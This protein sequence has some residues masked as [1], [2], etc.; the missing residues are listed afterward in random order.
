MGSNWIINGASID[1]PNS[2]NSYLAIECTGGVLEVDNV[3]ISNS[4]YGIYGTG[5]GGHI[6]NT[7]IDVYASS[8]GVKIENNS[9]MSLYKNTIT[10]N[11][12][13]TGIW[14]ETNATVVTNSNIVDG[15]A[16]RYAGQQP[17]HSPNLSILQ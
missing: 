14:S 16:N 8:Y 9:T 6:K 5:V 15:F 3:T 11:S 13:G 12:A 10:G 4:C 1:V 2:N 7:L 17:E